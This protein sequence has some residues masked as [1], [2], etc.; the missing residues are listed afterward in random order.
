M[1]FSKVCSLVIFPTF[2]SGFTRLKNLVS[3]N[4][5]QGKNL[6]TSLEQQILNSRTSLSR[7]KFEQFLPF[8][9]SLLPSTVE[10][11]FSP[12]SFLLQEGVEADKVHNLGLHRSGVILCQ[13]LRKCFS[14][15]GKSICGISFLEKKDLLS[16]Y[17]HLESPPGSEML[18]KTLML[19]NL[20]LPP[21]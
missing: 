15:P 7:S 11:I 1:S 4:L 9:A 10:S 17:I 2:W 14:L 5:L 16:L 19:K 3:L 12:P 8:S 21:R 20:N 18:L 13:L 6:L